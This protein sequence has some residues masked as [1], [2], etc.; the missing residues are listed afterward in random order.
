MLGLPSGRW[1]GRGREPCLFCLADDVVKSRH[2]DVLAVTRLEGYLAFVCYS[3][4][5]EQAQRNGC[6][7]LKLD[8]KVMMSE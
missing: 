5:R 7:V 3:H 2:F 6:V 1:R 8:V 4:R